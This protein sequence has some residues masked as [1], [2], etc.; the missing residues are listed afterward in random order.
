MNRLSDAIRSLPNGSRF[1]RCAFQVNTFDYILRHKHPTPFKNETDYNAAIVKACLDG[2]I[3]VIGI[4]DHYRIKSGEGLAKAARAA[5]IVVFPGFE[6]VTR[7]GVHVLCLFD[8]SKMVDSVQSCISACG[9]HDDGEASPLGDLSASEL[10]DNSPKWE[11]QCILAHVTNTGGLFRALQAGKARSAIWRHQELGACAIPGPVDNAPE[12]VRPILKN[13][14]PAY[15]RDRQI[16]VLNCNDVKSP[17]DVS[18][19]GAWCMVKM[20]EPTIEGL[21]QAFLDPG[22]RIR[23]A[24]DPGPEEHIE[25]IGIVWETEGFLRGCQIH[26]NENLNVLIGGRGSGKSTVIESLRYVL[27]LEP[28]GNGAKDIHKGIVSGVLKSG[29]KI[30]LLVQSYQPDRRRF[31]IQRTVPD[32]PRVIDE[33]GDVMKLKPLDIVRGVAVYGQNELAELARSPEKLTSL[34][35]RFVAVDDA[36]DGH[37]QELIEK[38]RESR[39]GILDC[40][41]KA[42]RAD[43]QLAALPALMETLER[44]RAAGV[45]AKLK[46]RDAIIRAEGILTTAQQRLQPVREAREALAD[47]VDTDAGFLSDEALNGLPATETL[48]GL[49]GTLSRLKAGVEQAEELLDKALADAEREIAAAAAVVE[50]EKRSSQQAYEAALRELQKEKIDGN[51]FIKLRQDI[52]RLSPLQAQKAGF[53]TRQKAFE[54]RRRNELAA[55]DDLKRRRFQELE[56]AAKRVSRELPD[57]L[58]VTVRYGADRKALLELIKRRPGRFAEAAEA[59]AQKDDLSL[60]ALAEA[61]RAGKE[62]L[63]KQFGIPVTQGEKLAAAGRE[64]PME[65]EELDLPHAT[66]IELNVGPERAPPEWRK[67]GD[68]STGQKATALLYLLLLDAE[69]PLVLDQPEDNLDNRFISEG[70]VPR[71]RAEKRR[72]QFIFTSHNA[73]IPVLG[74][75]EL[76]IGM[77]AVGEAGDGHAEIP[78]E[79]MGSIDKKS[80]AA[81]AEEILEGGKEAFM[82]RRK[83]YNF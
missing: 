14:D 9:V 13:T 81:L 10:L 69:A 60:G 83:K 51:E 21:R 17:N 41:S 53:E 46:S 50:T 74:D 67:L 36:E 4:T 61:L 3:E 58:R 27:G 30:S 52:E 64:L 47:A 19:R 38:L 40:M 37:Y 63:N 31:L 12:D 71:I 7:E 11:M 59:L 48:R 26:F 73:N 16:S 28:V 20:T 44:Y 55:W 56:K 6:A 33:N 32:P 43:E 72:R 78:P 77:R 68:L 18:R 70:I 42:K 15:R 34:L 45:E 35:Y 62:A 8:P 5:G 39:Q 82:Q 1:F 49:G 25:F 57:R 2:G 79:Y 65:V 23:L 76:I 80:V 66:E 54:Q 24:S 29:T 22:S 75:A